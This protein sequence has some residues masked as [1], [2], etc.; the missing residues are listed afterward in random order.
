M[1]KAW[2]MEK[3]KE[4]TKEKARARAWAWIQCKQNNSGCCL[5]SN[6]N[7]LRHLTERWAG[8]VD[9]NESTRRVFGSGRTGRNQGK[10]TPAGVVV[11]VMVGR[12]AGRGGV[13]HLTQGAS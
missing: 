8:I 9:G 1:V 13:S 11:V 2:R 10:L 6:N 5:Q 4:R 12:Q 3:A 7:R